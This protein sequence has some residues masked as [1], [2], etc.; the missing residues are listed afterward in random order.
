MQGW[1]FTMEDAHTIALNLDESEDD[2]NTFFA[3]Y[4]GHGGGAAAKY[5]GENV[6]K[7]LKS[8]EAYQHKEYRAALKNAFLGTDDDMRHAPEMQ[9][10][11]SG[12]TAVAALVTKEGKIFVANAGDS[13]SVISV[14][15]EAKPLSFDHKPQNEVEKSRIAAAGGY[16]S[17]G[18]VNGNLALAR[19]LGDFDYKRNDALSP[20]AQII[21]CDPEITEHDMTDED[22]FFVVACDGIWDCLSSQQCVDVIRL[23]ISQGKDLSQVC[24][25]ICELCLAPDT[26]SG[27]GIGCDNMTILI[28]AV[29]H[30]RTIEEWYKWI[31]ERTQQ[32]YGHTTPEELP[33]LYSQSRLASFRAR[34]EAW[35]ARRAQREAHNASSSSSPDREQRFSDGE[36]ENLS[37]PGM[38]GGFARVLGS[39]GGISFHPSTGLTIDA[40]LMF[41]NDDDD[42][43]DS[44]EADMEDVMGIYPAGGGEGHDLPMFRRDATKSLKEQLD[45]LEREDNE[46]DVDM[47]QNEQWQ[48]DPSVNGDATPQPQ[49]ATPPGG[50]EPSPVVKAEGLLDKSEDPLKV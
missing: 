7:K 23:M 10:D 26:N 43:N 18:R 48:N 22:E 47:Q 16:I 30:G 11:G 13:R 36:D 21:T 41:D 31:A 45:E 29:L 33:Q 20:E 8:D 46:G 28:V 38:F 37:G 1:R 35:E 39:T 6:H 32:Q 49:H 4:D 44:D 9:R 5:A 50:D 15:G 2:T 40:P 17:F 42:D 12:C 24:E 19:A 3:V 34:R 25:E 14:K 27:A